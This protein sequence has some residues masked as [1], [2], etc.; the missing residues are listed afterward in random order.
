M[1]IT[2]C[3]VIL[4]HALIHL[5]G[6]VKA[7]NLIEVKQLTQ[8]ISK[9]IGLLWLL[10]SVLML[11][12]LLFFL[13]KSNY[14][15]ILA[16]LAII[17]SQILITSNWHDAR[18]GTI[19][20]I[21]ILIVLVM[22]YSTSEFYAHFK[23]DVNINLKQADHSDT[24]IL[25][26]QDMVNLPES[27]KKYIRY[28][29]CVGKPKVNNFQLRFNGKIRANEQSAWM[30]F[31]SVQYNFIQTPARFFFMNAE[32]KHLPVAGYHRY[33]NGNASMDIRLLSLF[34]VQYQQ[35]GK[36]NQ[37]ETVTFFNDMCCAAPAT[38]IDPRIK[39]LN[40][41]G[42]NVLA[43]FTNNEITIQAWLYFNELGALTNFVSNDRYSLDARKI[44]PWSTPL[45]DYKEMNGFRLMSHAETIYSYPDRNECYGTFEL[46]S[47]E[48]NCSS[49]N[50]PQP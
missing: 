30:P 12:S 37:S 19:L 48:Y 32:L 8:T 44:L 9:P 25:N 21:I 40:E 4:I 46:T 18:F 6:F 20:N 17:L 10:T 26:E 11:S 14:W 45:H 29:G 41:D 42:N 33:M 13:L 1:K 5:L 38:L 7:F 34:K 27:V 47:V 31:K 16:L 35:G 49:F 23:S 2:F 22:S 39:W 24:S 15:H 3:I 43:S 28:A 50:V 36:M